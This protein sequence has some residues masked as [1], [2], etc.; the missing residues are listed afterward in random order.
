MADTSEFNVGQYGIFVEFL[1]ETAQLE[2]NFAYFCCFATFSVTIKMVR[3]MDKITFIS[4]ILIR[5]NT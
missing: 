2:P 3:P 5:Q 1:S 4:S